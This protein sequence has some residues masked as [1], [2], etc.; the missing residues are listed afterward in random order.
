[1]SRTQVGQGWCAV[2]TPTALALILAALQVIP[3]APDAIR[4][5]PAMI[6]FLREVAHLAARVVRIHKYAD[7]TAVRRDNGVMKRPAHADAPVA[8]SAEEIAVNP[9]SNAKMDRAIARPVSFAEEGSVVLKGVPA[10]LRDV[11]P[12]ARKSVVYAA[13]VVVRVVQPAVPQVSSATTVH[14]AARPEPR[15]VATD[16]VHPGAR[17]R[18]DGVNVQILPHYVDMC[19]VL[20][21]APV[22]RVVAGAPLVARSLSNVER[23]AVMPMSNATMGSQGVCVVR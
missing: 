12:L 18:T 16:V 5:P 21:A 19:A 2:R 11:V 20:M 7:R 6:G 22:F 14:A 1:M 13:R 9:G 4:V 17:A 23:F 15:L 8:R 3:I 10:P